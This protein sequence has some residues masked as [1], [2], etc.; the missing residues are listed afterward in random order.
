M[1]VERLRRLPLFGELDHHDL[2]T[3]SRLAR[4]VDVRNGDFV[5]QQD[6]I[7]YELFVIE[8]GTAEVLHDGDHVAD[9][10]PGDV[11]GEM[12][13]LKQ[14]RRW[15]SVR[16]TSRL[17]AVAL[18]TEGLSSMAEGMPELVERIEQTMSRRDLENQ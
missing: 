1:D 14:R 10:G 3:I 4:E 5:V 6:E 7:P 8:E 16:A 13:L 12:G 18:D 9:L 15:G 2:T 17:R 11:V